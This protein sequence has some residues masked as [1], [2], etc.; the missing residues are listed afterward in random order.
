MVSGAEENNPF[1]PAQPPSAAMDTNPLAS[2]NS[3]DDDAPPPAGVLHAAAPASAPPAPPA[4]PA[5]V[6]APGVFPSSVLQ[7]IDIR[8]H[9]PITLDL[10]AGNCAQWR[11]FFFTIVGMFGVRDHLVAP[12]APRRRDPEWVMVD[13]C[14]VH[15]LY[16]TISPELLDA[17]MQPDDTADILWGAIEE[18]FRANQLSRAVYIDAE[19]HAVVQGDLTVMQYFARLK[20]FTDQLRDLGQ[21]VGDTQQLFHMLRGLG[22]QY[23]GA[24]PHLTARNPLPTLLQA[25]S[26]LLLEEH[27]AE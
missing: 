21:S 27:R 24:V 11:R 3:S 4:P 13:H 17:V 5:P 6:L 7:T 15:W 23:H 20:T 26:F 12:A 25:R 1:A 8:H 9:V 18:I 2:P 10:H 22:R 16:A 14:I 19:Y